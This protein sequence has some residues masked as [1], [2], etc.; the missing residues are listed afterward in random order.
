[1]VSAAYGI[2]IAQNFWKR[3][4][5]EFP[6]RFSVPVGFGWNR[7]LQGELQKRILPENVGWTGYWQ[8]FTPP[9]Q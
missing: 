6:L 2:T 7:G 5:G 1:M 8:E 9:L 4:D 3:K